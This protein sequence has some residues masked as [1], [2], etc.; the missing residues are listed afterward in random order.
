MEVILSFT[1]EKTETVAGPIG[2][3]SNPLNPCTKYYLFLRANAGQNIHGIQTER[4]PSSFRVI[5][6]FT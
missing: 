4:R 1:D 2:P 6:N 3:V 5:T